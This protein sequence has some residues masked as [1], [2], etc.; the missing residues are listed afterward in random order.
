MLQDDTTLGT[1]FLD[2]LAKMNGDRFERNLPNLM[3]KLA[4]DLRQEATTTMQKGAASF[5]RSQSR[6]SAHILCNRLDK[7]QEDGSPVALKNKFSEIT[8]PSGVLDSVND[9]DEGDISEH[10]ESDSE[11][12]DA[13]L[14]LLE[15]EL[16]V[17]RSEAFGKFHTSLLYFVHPQR[18]EDESIDDDNADRKE[19]IKNSTRGSALSEGL[20]ETSSKPA[21]G[22]PIKKLVQ[23]AVEASALSYTVFA[24]YILVL[25]FEQFVRWEPRVPDQ[26]T[27]VRWKCVSCFTVL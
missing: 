10:E 26:C 9:I 21:K 3:R 15:L 16:F 5:I 20:E 22:D 2:G 17:K 27:R 14:D 7:S 12:E 18:K 23:E 4:L 19:H 13:S 11:G 8:S 1:L 6:N 25:A 24:R